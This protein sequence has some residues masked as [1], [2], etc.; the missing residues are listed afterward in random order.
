MTLLI[1]TLVVCLFTAQ[2]GWA[3]QSSKLLLSAPANLECDEDS[4][5]DIV[6]VRVDD[7]DSRQLFGYNLAVTL[8]VATE[9]AKVSLQNLRGVKV[10]V[11][12]IFGDVQFQINGALVDVQRALSSIIYTTPAEFAGMDTLTVSAQSTYVVGGQRKLGIVASKDILITV[13]PQNDAPVIFA[14]SRID[15][16]E[17]EN[18]FFSLEM[19]DELLNGNEYVLDFRVDHGTLSFLETSTPV[20]ENLSGIADVVPCTPGIDHY[21]HSCQFVGNL[22]SVN[23]IFSNLR[24]SPP[25]FFN[26]IEDGVDLLAISAR[27][28]DVKSEVNILAVVE[29]VNNAPML[30]C[31][32]GDIFSYSTTKYDNDFTVSLH[33]VFGLESPL[34]IDDNDKYDMVTVEIDSTSGFVFFYRTVPKALSIHESSTHNGHRLKFSGPTAAV[35]YALKLIR[36]SL[37]GEKDTVSIIVRDKGLLEDGCVGTVVSSVVDEPPYITGLPVSIWGDEDTPLLLPSFR[38]ELANPL[39]ASVVRVVLTVSSGCFSYTPKES[40]Y[41]DYMH[42]SSVLNSKGK[43]QRSNIRAVPD[44]ISADTQLQQLVLYGTLSV[45]NDYLIEAVTYHPVADSNT[46][47]GT[48]PVFSVT[49]EEYNFNTNSSL[50]EVTSSDLNILISS[51]NDVAVIMAPLQYQIVTDE[52]TAVSLGESGLYVFDADAQETKADLEVFLTVTSGMLRMPEPAGVL[53]L[54]DRQA[55]LHFL[56]QLNAV[57][58]A[59]KSVEY[60][61]LQN[62]HGEDALVVDVFDSVEA[63]EQVNIRIQVLPVNDAPVIVAPSRLIVQEDKPTLVPGLSVNDVDFIYDFQHSE[64]MTLSLSVAASQIHEPSGHVRYLVGD[65]TMAYREAMGSLTMSGTQVKWEKGSTDEPTSVLVITGTPDGIH[66]A[67]TTLTYIPPVDFAGVNILSLTLSDLGYFGSVMGGMSES[68]SALVTEKHIPIIV[69]SRDDP[70]VITTAKSVSAV[71]YQPTSLVDKITLTDADVDNAQYSLNITCHYC[72]WKL[73]RSLLDQLGIFVSVEKPTLSGDNVTYTSELMLRGDISIMQKALEFVR[74]VS[75]SAHTVNDDVLLKMERINISPSQQNF[76][77]LASLVIEVTGK[78][79]SPTLSGR[80][81]HQMGEDTVV[82]FPSLSFD[83]DASLVSSACSVIIVYDSEHLTIAED[84]SDGDNNWHEVNNSD[85]LS[86]IAMKNVECQSITS[87]LERLLLQPSQNVNYLNAAAPYVNATI[88][89]P[90]HSNSLVFDDSMLTEYVTHSFLVYIAPENDAPIVTCVGTNSSEYLGQGCLVYDV[91][92]LDDATKSNVLE[93][94]F[95]VE[96]GI[97]EIEPL[98]LGG[99]G[100]RVMESTSNYLRFRGNGEDLTIAL[101]K[102]RYIP[103]ETFGLHSDDTKVERLSIIVTDMGQPPLT[104]TLEMDV[105]VLHRNRSP[106]IRSMSRDRLEVK[107][108]EKSSPFDFVLDDVDT[109][110]LSLLLEVSAG[111]LCYGSNEFK[112]L[113]INGTSEDLNQIVHTIQYLSPQN[114]NVRTIGLVTVGVHVTDGTGG[115]A[116][117]VYLIQIIPTNDAP[118]IAMKSSILRTHSTT[119]ITLENVTVFDIDS[120]GKALVEVSVNHGSLLPRGLDSTAILFSS[121]RLLRFSGSISAVNYA[122]TQIEYVA[123]TTSFV[124]EDILNIIVQDDQQAQVQSQVEISI[125]K[126]LQ[127]N[128]SIGFTKRVLTG[129]EDQPIHLSPIL[130]SDFAQEN[131]TLFRIELSTSAASGNSLPGPFIF[132][133][134]FVSD[135]E[136]VFFS[137]SYKDNNNGLEIVGTVSEIVNKIPWIKLVP[138]EDFNGY[139]YVLASVLAIDKINLEKNIPTSQLA[140]VFQ[141]VNDAPLLTVW[142]GGKRGPKHSSSSSDCDEDKPCYLEMTLTDVDAAEMS[143]PGGNILNIDI[144]VA[145]TWEGIGSSNLSLEFVDGPECRTVHST[146]I[147]A[148]PYSLACSALRMKSLNT[149][150]FRVISNVNFFGERIP[151]VVSVEDNGSCGTGGSKTANTT[152]ILSIKPINDP[153]SLSVAAAHLLCKEDTLCNLPAIEITDVDLSLR[154]VLT[155]TAT[156]KNGIFITPLPG[157]LLH[158]VRVTVHNASSV[159][160]SSNNASQLS[161]YLQLVQYLPRD[162]YHGVWPAVFNEDG[163]HE[164]ISAVDLLRFQQQQIAGYGSVINPSGNFS[165]TLEVAHFT[166]SDE[167][168]HVGTHIAISVDWVNDA[169]AVFGPDEII[170][171][172]D[173]DYLN[174]FVVEDVDFSSDSS[175][176]RKI[177]LLKLAL[178]SHR[179]LQLDFSLSDLTRS[180]VRNSSTCSLQLPYNTSACITEL[181]G[182]PGALTQALHRTLLTSHSIR[183]DIDNLVFIVT[184]NNSFGSGGTFSSEKTVTVKVVGSSGGFGVHHTGFINDALEVQEDEVM[185]LGTISLSLSPKLSWSHSNE[186]NLQAPPTVGAVVTSVAGGEF[187]TITNETFTA[188][189]LHRTFK[190]DVVGSGTSPNASNDLFNLKLEGAYRYESQTVELHST[191]GAVPPT[192]VDVTVS[193]SAYDINE[194]S[195]F[196]LKG[197]NFL[198]SA[199]LLSE[200]LEKLQNIGRVRV[201]PALRNKTSPTTVYGY[202]HVTFLTNAGNLPLLEI[203][204]NPIVADNV[205]VKCPWIEVRRTETG[206]LQAEEQEISIENTTSGEFVLVVLNESGGKRFAITSNMKDLVTQSQLISY[207]STAANLT[208]YELQRALAQMSDIVGFTVVT[209]VGMS[210]SSKY[211]ITFLTKGGDINNLIVLWASG[212]SNPELLQGH[213]C[214]SCTGMSGATVLVAEV[215]QG[216]QPLNGYIKFV[217]T[218][219]DWTFTSQRMSLHATPDILNSILEEIPGIKKVTSTVLDC[220]NPEG[221]CI[222]SFSVHK[223]DNYSKIPNLKL[224]ITNVRSYPNPQ[225]TL[226]HGI[227]GND[228]LGVRSGAMMRI[229]LASTSDTG[230]MSILADHTDFFPVLNSS[231]ASV[232]SVIRAAL[233]QLEPCRILVNASKQVTKLNA[234]S[235]VIKSVTFLVT[236]SIAEKPFRA[237][238]NG[239]YVTSAGSVVSTRSR[240]DIPFLRVSSEEHVTG[241]PVSQVQV[242]ELQ[243]DSRP[244]RRHMVALRTPTWLEVRE[245]QT[246]SCSSNRIATLNDVEHLVHHAEYFRLS[247]RQEE[248]D[249]IWIHN[250]VSPDFLPNCDDFNLVSGEACKN[251]GSSLLERILSMSTIAGATI[252]TNST[253]GR[254]CPMQTT[255]N[256]SNLFSDLV[257]EVFVTSIEFTSKTDKPSGQY[258]TSGSDGNVPPLL[259]QNVSLSDTTIV[260]N[261]EVVRGSKSQIHE[262]QE[263]SVEMP[264]NSS[265]VAYSKNSFGYLK[266]LMSDEVMQNTK[267][268]RIL[269]TASANQFQKAVWELMNGEVELNSLIVDRKYEVIEQSDEANTVHRY[270]WRVTFPLS[271]GRVPLLRADETCDAMTTL[272]SNSAFVHTLAG[273]SIYLDARDNWSG[274]SCLLQGVSAA[275]AVLSSKRIVS[276]ITP[277]TGHFRLLSSFPIPFDVTVPLR[278]EDRAAHLQ[279]QLRQVQGLEQATV[280]SKNF[281]NW[282]DYDVETMLVDF[283]DVE[284]HHVTAVNEVSLTAESCFEREDGTIRHC[285]FPFIHN[286]KLLST[287]ISRSKLSVESECPDAF[288]AETAEWGKCKPCHDITTIANMHEKQLFHPVTVSPVRNLVRFSGELGTVKAV[289]GNLVYVPG[290]HMSSTASNKAQEDRV[291][292]VATTDAVRMVTGNLLV[293]DLTLHIKVIGKDSEPIISHSPFGITVFQDTSS[294]LPGIRLR[295]R[296]SPTTATMRQQ[297]VAVSMS[298]DHGNLSL[299]IHE[300]IYF[301]D[302]VIPGNLTFTGSLYDVNKALESLVYAPSAGWNSVTCGQAVTSSIFDLEISTPKGRVELQKIFTSVSDSMAGV[303]DHSLSRFSLSL[304]C[305]F[306]APGDEHSDIAL[307]DWN[308]TSSPLATNSSEW[309]VKQ[310]VEIMLLQCASIISSNFNI[311][312]HTLEPDVI[313]TVTVSKAL[314]PTKVA[315]GTTSWVVSFVNIPER[316]VGKSLFTKRRDNIEF[317]SLQA[318]NV[319]LFLVQEKGS[320]VLARATS[321]SVSIKKLTSG[322]NAPQ[323]HFYLSVNGIQSEKIEVGS[324]AAIVES[325]LESMPNVNDVGV[326]D[327]SIDDLNEQRYGYLYEIEFFNKVNWLQDKYNKSHVASI[328]GSIAFGNNVRLEVIHTSLSLHG[329]DLIARASKLVDGQ[330][331]NDFLTII[332]FDE[333]DCPESNASDSSGISFNASH[334]VVSTIPLYILPTLDDP[335]VRIQQQPKSI[336][337]DSHGTI[338]LSIDIDQLLVMEEPHITVVFIGND[339][340][341]KFHDANLPGNNFDQNILR[342]NVTDY[343]AVP[344]LIQVLVTGPFNVISE[345]LSSISLHPSHNYFGQL[346]VHIVCFMGSMIPEGVDDLLLT[347]MTTLSLDVLPEFDALEVKRLASPE[348]IVC[349]IGSQSRPTQLLTISDPDDLDGTHLISVNITTEN[350]GIV[351]LPIYAYNSV[352]GTYTIIDWYSLKDYS[353]LN[354]TPSSSII[355]TPI[356]IDR[357]LRNVRFMGDSPSDIIR[358]EMGRWGLMQTIGDVEVMEF[359]VKGVVGVRD[360]LVSVEVKDKIVNIS[361]DNLLKNLGVALRVATVLND[362]RRVELLLSCE[363]GLLFLPSF[364]HEFEGVNVVSFGAL[365]HLE[366][367]NL[368]I[369]NEILGMVTYSP[370]PNFFGSVF[371]SASVTMQDLETEEAPLSVASGQLLVIVESVDDPPV[372]SLKYSSPYVMGEKLLTTAPVALK[373]FYVS[374]IDDTTPLLVVMN[375]SRGR[376]SLDLLA[377][378]KSAMLPLQTFRDFSDLSNRQSNS[379]RF[380]VSV[381]EI[382]EVLDRIEYIPEEHTNHKA[383]IVLSVS[384]LEAAVSSDSAISSDIVPFNK[385]AHISSSFEIGVDIPIYAAFNC[386]KTVQLMEDDN[387]RLGTACDLRLRSVHSLDDVDIRLKI[388]VGCDTG[389]LLLS[390]DINENMYF[391]P[392]IETKRNSS[393]VMLERVSVNQ[394]N[395]IL[396]SISYVPR[397]NFY[398]QDS[399]FFHASSSPYTDLSFAADHTL[400]LDIIPTF[401]RPIV[402]T[403]DGIV[404]YHITDTDTLSMSFLT[405]SDPDSLSSDVKWSDWLDVRIHVLH[406]E[407]RSSFGVVSCVRNFFIDRTLHSNLEIFD[408]G[409]TSGEVHVRGSSEA[410]TTFLSRGGVVFLPNEYD[411][412]STA[413]EPHIASETVQ[414]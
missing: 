119:T 274:K 406:T 149:I 360:G 202:L 326:V 234:A 390:K 113:T 186:S 402:S 206:T 163:V 205:S 268:V 414:N 328:D 54:E 393:I 372:I 339:Y 377:E 253:T 161:N 264:L 117:H 50:S 180:G 229:A 376:L 88:V 133:I 199:N 178:F 48:T 395:L 386:P 349:I 93:V 333:G 364:Q 61:P 303:L 208:T 411:F 179:G 28:G 413:D 114:Q 188:T 255:V 193:F 365:L 273:Q 196:L 262:V 245:L 183:G 194:S 261:T 122:L 136:T 371:L 409:Y 142:T 248:S 3:H 116:D 387:F 289:L 307:R 369:L 44:D 233:C 368:V 256:S 217:A 203:K 34:Y 47:S 401:D 374:D 43:P 239:A 150:T 99:Q 160:V 40:L 296:D 317:P 357:M 19:D 385:K 49:A 337:E 23:L 32:V 177:G 297:H 134:S 315:K 299:L 53:V 302:F 82:A 36:Y 381:E 246:I 285:F 400:S 8:S 86:C 7:Y 85:V 224:D 318:V 215:E 378:R 184:D 343:D 392:D 71:A 118:E 96:A 389:S 172:G 201:V 173:R 247:F 13:V 384:S 352:S 220:G 347:P 327:K 278:S 103:V 412:E 144:R 340:Q 130:F 148:K 121:S 396:S 167:S 155:V 228:G 350:G 30:S 87:S 101:G 254:I 9:G 211:K 4:S 388:T 168:S 403:S 336:I 252:D 313:P 266:L 38:I 257:D 55:S 16:N 24:Y 89:V 325:V 62:F 2:S 354:K 216:T 213:T 332:A 21:Y 407:E 373:A 66:N 123:A 77:S 189:P 283:V 135:R 170:A 27:D 115:Y 366:G 111:S 267:A 60:I 344:G 356:T 151:I 31:H 241:L 94:T 45:V 272:H 341:L 335:K 223:D 100:Y 330:T 20:S 282:G 370:P 276:G 250:A 126:D 209:Q 81:I 175:T 279:G 362:K 73:Q 104:T 379:V 214:S 187:A 280:V 293:S 398:G 291:A 405:I 124:S 80:K 157:N 143:C 230:R 185:P 361:E 338:G 59:L 70:A 232:A 37:S 331:C 107:E 410:I 322:N 197:E 41:A 300:G 129:F 397:E 145:P 51:V 65:A 399:L 290:A 84:F 152:A 12:D 394:V 39:P 158:S 79:L 231:A 275:N 314:N 90:T 270:S 105:P 204:V 323:G 319:S 260:T 404:T 127:V 171:T 226:T 109:Q 153:P 348:A 306:F 292:V 76:V 259:V 131:N 218:E 265:E 227:V 58:E 287:C 95:A 146:D 154:E 1:L 176:F 138:P 222:W 190:I 75:F 33:M 74:Y 221:N 162:N 351:S 156:V 98:D 35:N 166:V 219:D 305:Q 102:I 147:A 243:G 195:T 140:A 263:F 125:Q 174:Q 181:E 18:A 235:A 311:T 97:L 308:V 139:V 159:V 63:A 345:A 225:V 312:S 108:D 212:S 321:A 137:V 304:D 251:D 92:S 359:H 78:M 200:S 380:F 238:D 271:V 72:D 391:K 52:D 310:A 408:N 309:D 164:S 358:V 277:L 237:Y 25:S 269:S 301:S 69:V 22:T 141:P 329:R 67:L 64:V 6:S 91:D 165:D 342:I 375:C 363:E 236:L 240:H 295:D 294:L 191:D 106:V 10:T 15:C 112:S 29:P 46:Y 383:V 110:S 26:K 182:T 382:N 169:P 334:E 68:G 298:V 242:T 353:M 120:S 286:E 198:P 320:S 346:S 83:Y 288:E 324:P 42:P 14:P 17:G 355:G 57:N 56:G 367:N 210:N 316:G 128:G 132:D 11:G 258:V 249:S 207:N 192:D 284:P 5:V 244:H 281:N